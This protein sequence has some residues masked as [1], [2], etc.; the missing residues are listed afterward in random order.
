MLIDQSRE[1]EDHFSTEPSCSSK[2]FWLRNTAHAFIFLL[3]SLHLNHR[4][5]ASVLHRQYCCSR[6]DSLSSPRMPP[7]V[8][9]VEWIIYWL[10]SSSLHSIPILAL[11]DRLWAAADYRSTAVATWAKKK[12][13]CKFETLGLHWGH[14]HRCYVASKRIVCSNELK[15]MLY[16][17][18]F[19]T[20]ERCFCVGDGCFRRCLMPQ[21]QCLGDFE[22]C[23][24]GNQ[25]VG[26]LKR[27]G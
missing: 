10:L 11:N 19:V 23:F 3:Y 26:D 1:R 15:L 12:I 16:L 24:K 21:S 6:S 25:Y 22:R 14:R 4:L 27:D 2:L 20:P 13:E 7:K 8:F 9:T 5:P 17:M 18:F